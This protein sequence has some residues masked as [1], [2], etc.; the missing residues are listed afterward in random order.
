MKVFTNQ[1]PGIEVRDGFIVVGED[2]KKK[3]GTG[4]GKV[5]VHGVPS[6][7]RT[8]VTDLETFF[9]NSGRVC[10]RLPDDLAT[11]GEHSNCVLIKLSAGPK[12]FVDDNGKV[13]YLL[14]HFNCHGN[15]VRLAHGYF[16]VDVSGNE[17]DAVLKSALGQEVLALVP[18][19]SQI[20][21]SCIY[22]GEHPVFDH[23]LYVD[24]QGNVEK[25]GEIG[26]KIRL[27]RR[28]FSDGAIDWFSE[29]PM[30]LFTFGVDGKIVRGIRN[31]YGKIKFGIH[32]RLIKGI[33]GDHDQLFFIPFDLDADVVMQAKIGKSLGGQAVLSKDD[34][35]LVDHKI[36]IMIHSEQRS[37]LSDNI[38]AG[39]VVDLKDDKEAE[40]VSS[41]SDS[42]EY[43]D[44]GKNSLSVL[45][46]TQYFLVVA[47]MGWLKRISEKFDPECLSLQFLS[48]IPGKDCRV[49]NSKGIPLLL[50]MKNGLC[51]NQECENK[52]ESNNLRFKC[53]VCGCGFCSDCSI[54]IDFDANQTKCPKCLE[55]L[56]FE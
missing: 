18:F 37:T 7:E 27:A 10:L 2:L 36:A 53:S 52:S 35:S 22:N 21:V 23:W 4:L 1:I 6:N 26:R 30:K 47:T 14:P 8:L 29:K 16:S 11:V 32:Q 13:L 12:R 54:D 46:K 25:V 20:E 5:V 19:N 45:V 9:D 15:T 50:F 44:E 43:V 39:F 33:P 56:F 34:G 41:I 31:R 51:E 24:G 17:K 48:A 28:D 40:I 38:P 42:V 49:R 3:V 55:V